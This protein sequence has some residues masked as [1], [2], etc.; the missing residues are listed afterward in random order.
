M[1]HVFHLPIVYLELFKDLEFR[2]M[3]KYGG[4]TMLRLQNS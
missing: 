3:N 2:V 1:Y 4:K